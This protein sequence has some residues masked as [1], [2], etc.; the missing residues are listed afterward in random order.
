LYLGTTA[1]AEQ[2]G[3]DISGGK[4][5]YRLETVTVTAQKQEEN[6]QD[7]P[8][9]ITVVSEQEV[10]D[11]NIESIEDVADFVPNFMINDEGGSGMNSPVMRGIYAVTETLTVSS[12]LFVDGVPF[13]SP[14]GYEDTVLDIER[15]EVL[16]GPQGTLYGKNTETGA[17]NIITRQPDNEFRAK[18]SADVGAL[19][20]AETGDRL[21]QAYSLNLSGP[22]QTDKLFIGIAG[23]FYQKDGFIKNT[24]TGDTTDDRENWFG[25]AHLR[26]TPSDRLDISFIAS[27]LGYDDEAVN[28]NLTEYGTAA[29]GLSEAEDR[30]VASNIQ[31]YNKARSNTQSLKIKYNFTDSLAL[32]SVTARREYHDRSLT[33]W[34]FSPTTLMH[35]DKDNTYTKISQE[36]RLDS[37]TDKMKWLIG[38]YYDN[39]ENEIDMVTDSVYSMMAS[40]KRRDFD[41]DAYAAF[42]HISYALTQRFRVIG[43]LRYETQEQEYENH[44]QNTKTD[45]SWNEVS[46][47]LGL[48]YRWTPAMMSYASVSRGYR[49]GGFNTSATDPRYTSYDEEKLWSYEIGTKCLFWDDRLMLNGCI[50]L[51][52]ISD[53]Q[54]TEAVSPVESYMTNAAE[55]TAKGFEV[56]MTA[57]IA[58]GLMLMGG[59]G[60]ID[61]EFDEFKDALGDYE[62][63]KNPYAPE[64]TFNI[65]AQYRFQ[66][67]LYARADLIGYG[68]MYLDR[69]N[70]YKRDAYEIVNA[71]IGY[72]TEHFDI[73]LYGKNI[74]DEEYNSYGYY[75]GYYVVY[76]DPGEAGLQVVYRF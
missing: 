70:K 3:R 16:R 54:V 42:G 50:F 22:I 65:G 57:R 33:D 28:M 11:A 20:S 4:N 36:L 53:M 35:G 13:L 21:K 59:F 47:K 46:P 52:D 40:T 23:K 38:L 19:L 12:G 9:S 61:I 37:S 41:G 62:D 48:E 44:I 60:Y 15:I 6:V 67:G 39:D 7:V 76:S 63:N 51:M 2:E 74:F 32:T 1:E 64:Y 10:E 26:W 58:D 5:E 34:D 17:I 27:S 49:S 30:K 31:G 18:L 24:I 66:N 29:F 69:A 8:V 55:A 25:R 14:T 56:E 75:D 45:E 68:E 73:Y 72:E 71:K 43:G